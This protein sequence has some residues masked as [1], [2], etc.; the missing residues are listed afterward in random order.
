MLSGGLSVN[1]G[2]KCYLGDLV[3]PGGL[4]VIWGI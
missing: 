1:R 3:L 2:I 4:S